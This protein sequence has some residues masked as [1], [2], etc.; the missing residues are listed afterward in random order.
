VK[1]TFLALKI[2]AGVYFI[3]SIALIIVG[4]LQPEGG[5]PLIGMGLFTSV[6]GFANLKIKKSLAAGKYWAWVTAIVVF[7][8]SLFSIFL[9]LSVMGLVGLLKKETR[10]TFAGND[11]V[12]S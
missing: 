4:F 7:G 5:V 1:Y 6:L 8:L 9:P 2:Q 12:S 11:L 10:Q 3:L